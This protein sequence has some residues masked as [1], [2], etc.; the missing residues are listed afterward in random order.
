MASG[1][2][3]ADVGLG[4][5][6][7]LLVRVA[8]G[9]VHAVGGL[10]LQLGEYVG[11]GVHGDRNAGVAEDLHHDAGVDV[12][13]EQQARAGMPQVMQSDAA[14]AGAV[15]EGAEVAAEVVGVHRPTR[16]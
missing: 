2:V 4:R 1:A 13:R 15:T 5:F 3:G 8:E 9:L 14:D 7:V 6:F 11:V 12:L 16:R 10:A